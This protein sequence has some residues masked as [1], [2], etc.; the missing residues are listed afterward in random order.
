MVVI[1]VLVTGIQRSESSGASGGLDPRDKP[2]DDRCGRGSV[3]V[4]YMGGMTKIENPKRRT[5]VNPAKVGSVSQ[6]TKRAQAAR[7]G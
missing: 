2:E 3:V 4:P 5:K 1:P 6:A 7:D